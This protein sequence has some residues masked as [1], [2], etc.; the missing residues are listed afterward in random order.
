MQDRTK[1]ALSS[2]AALEL[3]WQTG[4]GIMALATQF[5]PAT[6]VVS[7]AI[8]AAAA[9]GRGTYVYFHPK[10]AIS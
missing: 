10:P 2:A 5:Q 6:L 8:G 3:G 7:E 1:Q 9:I 4:T